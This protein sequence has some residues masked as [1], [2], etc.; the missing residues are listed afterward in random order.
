MGVNAAPI[1]ELDT[2]ATRMYFNLGP[3]KDLNIEIERQ[4][5]KPHK[6]TLRFE[7]KFEE[8][9]AINEFQWICTKVFKK[10]FLKPKVGWIIEIVKLG[11][12]LT[13]GYVFG[14]S[15]PVALD[16]AFKAMMGKLESV[17][18]QSKILSVADMVL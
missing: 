7:N 6:M 3:L 4:E 5:E 12:D 13:M 11:E 10:G 1:N 8:N 2:K 15:Q 9:A 17:R 18:E 14:K 16:N